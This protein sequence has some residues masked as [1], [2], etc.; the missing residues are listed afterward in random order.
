[1]NFYLCVLY[2]GVWGRCYLENCKRK[3]IFV[4]KKILNEWII[5]VNMG[6]DMNKEEFV[7]IDY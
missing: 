2:E 3:L 4:N 1:M 6:I 7:F 5:D